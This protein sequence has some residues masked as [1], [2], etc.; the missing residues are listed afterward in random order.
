MKRSFVSVVAITTLIGSVGLVAPV[1]AGP[2]SAGP[3]SAGVH[4][5]STDTVL[6]DVLIDALIVERLPGRTTSAARADIEATTT[7]D[8]T[9]GTKLGGR[10]ETIEFDAPISA[11]NALELAA[12]LEADG[13]VVS[14]EPDYPR[15]SATN[16]TN[17]NSQ[18]SLQPYASSNAGI[19]LEAAWAASPGTHDVVVAVID[20]GRPMFNGADH[21]D[22]VG[23]LVDGRDFMSLSGVYDPRDGNGWDDDETDEG[24]WETTG[25]CGSGSVAQNS[26]WHGSHVAG[27]IAAE[28]NNNLGIAGINPRAKVQH[29]RVLG[30][31]GGSTSDEA[32]A[33]RWAAGLAVAGV[34]INRTPADVINLSLGGPG[35]CTSAEQQAIDAATKAGSIVVVA[36]GN[37][38]LDLD[39]SSY[40]PA[41]CTS[42]ITVAAVET[43]GSRLFLNN[44]TASNYG[45]KVEIAAPGRNVISTMNTG[46]TTSTSSWNYLGKT[47]T[48]MAT[49][50]VAGVVSLMLSHDNTL[51]LIQIIKLLQET[52]SPFPAGSTCSSNIAATNYCGPGIV[53]AGAV[54][55]SLVSVVPLDTLET[56]RPQRVL[57]TRDGTG[58]VPIARVGNTNGTTPDLAFTITGKGGVPTTGV[59][60]VSLNIT[61]TQTTAPDVGGYV[62][63]YPCA[64]G[65]PNVSNL[66]FVNGQTTPNT[67]IVPVDTNGQICLHVYGTA[68]LIIDVNGWFQN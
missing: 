57:D 8:T 28:S 17:W 29:I 25:Q 1:S 30:S 54:M 64:T 9:V 51:N 4:P 2:V 13:L 47:G 33:I 10:F 66:N 68:H 67:V 21:P 55:Q 37:D 23:N 46:T 16:D 63:V 42:V 62:T 43:N 20:T 34:P 59:D 38:N 31:C 6:D 5:A 18:W 35:P 58:G 65:R 24:D 39:V 53:N 12:S 19:G 60:A 48:S 61:A 50:T 41:S 15:H 26:S 3:V 11:A 45:S 49:P 56:F 36:A 27:I 52:A 44:S 22:M 7:L 40:S 14:A 32:A